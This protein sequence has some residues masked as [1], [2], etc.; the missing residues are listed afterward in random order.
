MLK[1][2]LTAGFAALAVVAV[3][4]IAFAAIAIATFFVFQKVA[5]PPIPYQISGII[6]FVTF[7][8]MLALGA[9]YVTRKGFI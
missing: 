4:A 7:Y 3:A 8:L 6:G 2:L 9:E 1:R 5:M